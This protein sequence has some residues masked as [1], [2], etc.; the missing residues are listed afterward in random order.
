MVVSS[1]DEANPDASSECRVY[2]KETYGRDRLLFSAEAIY[3]RELSPKTGFSGFEVQGDVTLADRKVRTKG[4]TVRYN[5]WDWQ[6][7]D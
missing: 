6:G 1:E 2:F 7:C 4:W 5:V 3:S